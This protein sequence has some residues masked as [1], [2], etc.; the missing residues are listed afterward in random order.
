MQTLKILR[1]KDFGFDEQP[2][3]LTL[4]EAARAVVVNQDGLLA[5]LYV[6]KKNFYKIP[7]GGVEAGEDLITALKREVHE[8]AGCDIEVLRELGEITEYRT[9]FKV[10]QKSYCYLAKVVGAIS[11][12]NFEPGELADGFEVKWRSLTEA[13][14]CINEVRTDDYLGRFVT[15]R[16]L[17]IIK[18]AKKY[19]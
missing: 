3:E 2:G 12:P 8:E 13:E 5:M 7:G 10:L 4:R 16:E 14:K 9:H 19:L 15:D 17:T 6:S 18:E 1:D 11:A